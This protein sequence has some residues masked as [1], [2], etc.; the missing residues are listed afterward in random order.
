MPVS[1]PHRSLTHRLARLCGR[2]ATLGSRAVRRGE[3]SVVGGAIAQKID[4]TIAREL[5]EGVRVALVSGTNG[6]TTTT[7]MITEAVS[8]VTLVANNRTGANLANGIVGA[9]MDTP[10]AD[11]AVL[12]VDEGFVPWALETLGPDMIVLLNL[13]RDQ[14]DRMHEVAALAERWQAAIAAHPP[15]VVVANAD[16][17]MVVYAAG[18]QPAVWVAA[19][20]SW[21][22]DATT[23]LWCGGVIEFP[24]TGWACTRCDHRR[25]PCAVSLD[26]D[27]VTAA[28]WTIE[29]ALPL[30][31]R[32]VRANAVMALAAAE[33]L[34]VPVAGAVERWR[35]IRSIEG[36]Y[37]V[38]D[39]AGTQ[40]RLHLAKNPAGWSDTLDMLDA[41]DLPVILVLN[42]RGQDG[43]DPSWIWDVP[44]D[45]LRGRTVVCMGERGTDL[46]VRLTY[47]DIDIREA[48]SLREAAAMVGSGPVHVVANYSAFQQLRPMV[49]RGR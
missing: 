23:C 20:L 21:T 39:F 30:P 3:G 43:R 36:R 17:P 4:P 16:D 44:F 46:A 11:T 47:A 7:R 45:Q 8:T 2:A 38:S 18:D 9:L 19:G 33:Q 29:L 42:A 14:L 22:T 12:E 1:P 24:P 5:A 15:R 40:V 10:R 27:T 28:D 13:S 31:G 32:S 34:D 25:P 6:K 41:D 37:E 48:A 35:S 49:A 26:G